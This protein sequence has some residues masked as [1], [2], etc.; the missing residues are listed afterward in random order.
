M[1]IVAF[2]LPQFHP[3]PENDAWWGAGFTEWSNV[4][5]ARPL[6]RGHHQPRLP[7]ELGFYDLRLPDTR[8]AQADLARD[9]G[10]EG[11]CYY[12]YWFSGRRLLER[13]LDEARRTGEPDFPFCLCWANETWSRRWIGEER[14]VLVAQAYSAEDDLDHARWLLGP[15]SDPRYLRV[16][17]RP[18]YLVYRPRDLPQPHRTTDLIRDE[19]ARAGCAEPWLVGV[20][21]H[22]PGFDCRVLG[23]DDTLVFAPQL[24]ALRAVWTGQWSARRF[25][26]NLR[27]GA[28]QGTTQIFG[29]PQALR[30]MERQR[31]TIFHIPCVF[32][33]WDNSPRRGRSS[34]VIRQATSRQFRA[35]LERACSL[36][37]KR[38]AE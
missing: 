21:A 3:I 27:H 31:P 4:A 7:G 28:M 26:R 22:C 35:A 25:V 30:A 5:R 17:G 11:F 8:S 13:P 38:P 32:P 9:H 33:G 1:R 2:Y 18:L 6:F 10:I 37:S 15:F 19:C 16:G 20:D 36:A 34:M 29:Y 24:G 12:H 14:D 23:F